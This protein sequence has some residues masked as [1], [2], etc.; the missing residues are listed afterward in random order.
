MIPPSGPRVCLGRPHGIERAAPARPER[1]PCETQRKA[2]PRPQA[3]IL[4]L[5]GARSETSVDTPDDGNAVVVRRSRNV[6]IELG[7]DIG[8][9]G[10]QAGSERVSDSA[11]QNVFAESFI[12]NGGK[13]QAYCA[14]SMIYDHKMLSLTHRFLFVHIPKTGGNSIQTI[15]RLY[16]EDRIVTNPLQDGVQRFEVR[17]RFTRHKHATLADYHKLIPP[18][19]FS[20]LFKFCVVRNPWSR[21]MSFYFSPHRW[22]GRGIAPY[23]SRDEFLALLPRLPPMVEYLKIYGRIQEMS[24]II[25]YERLTEHLPDVLSRIGIEAEKHR[26]PYLNRGFS[27]DYRPYFDKDQDLIRIVYAK[28]QE[29]IRHFGYEFDPD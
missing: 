29:D 20:D 12:A 21:S 13:S 16:S 27:E 7:M 4:S 26:L 24:F 10:R 9:A 18:E 3:P 11:S 1:E 23:W 22:I 5:F 17:G 28:Y 6:V 2:E 19:L 8:E 14:R 15:L 25:R